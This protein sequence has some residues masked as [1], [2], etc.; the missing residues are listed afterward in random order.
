MLDVDPER[1]RA[2]GAT[3]WQLAKKALNQW[4]DAP[5]G[6]VPQPLFIV[7]CQRSGTT[8]LIDTLMRAPDLWVHPEKS[9]LAY[10][11]F[12]LRSPATIA[13]IT[14]FTPASTVIYKPLCDAHL[15]D[16]ILAAH[17]TGHAWWVVRGWRDVAD[18]AV[19]KWGTHQRD[20]IL[21]LATGQGERWGWRTER[22]PEAMIAQL[23]QL[24][25]ADLT[26]EAG[27]ALFWYVRNSFY[28]SLGLDTD[29]RVTLVRY[30]NL[31][32]NPEQAFRPLFAQLGVTADPAWT[33]DIVDSSVG[34]QTAAD[35]PADIVAVCDALLQRF[36]ASSPAA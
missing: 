32:S 5:E 18:S 10:D 22:V 21:D 25:T 26:P 35:I 9:A 11:D 34:K 19:R 6:R 27:A 1:L 4:L 28:Y 16:R 7:G 3:A 30:E 29:P 2:H 13:A 23:R 14:R 8:M 24:V 20:V 12:R 33:A 17:R 36:V 31:V 15:T